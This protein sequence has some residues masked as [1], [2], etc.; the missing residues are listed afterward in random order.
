MLNQ[1][2]L[3]GNLGADPEV[4]YSSEGNPVTSFNIAFHSP[5][6]RPAGSV[7]SASRSSP[8]SP[9]STSTRAP[10]SLLLEPWIDMSGNPMKGVSKSTY[11][12]IANSLEFIKTDGQG[13]QGGRIQRRSPILRKEWGYAGENHQAHHQGRGNSNLRCNTNQRLF[14]WR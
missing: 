10:E 2:V 7:W 12:L 5:R 9:P 13:F 11:Q 14:Q 8:R 6:K 4:F 3:T 1:C